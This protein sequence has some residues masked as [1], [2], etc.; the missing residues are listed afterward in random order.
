MVKCG[1]CKH[2]REDDFFTKY[3]ER[4]EDRDD[5]DL[6]VCTVMNDVILP[7]TWRY[8]RREVMSPWRGEEIECARFEEIPDETKNT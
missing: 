8:A 7:Y 6:G 1:D 2:W 5:L 4:R 3:P